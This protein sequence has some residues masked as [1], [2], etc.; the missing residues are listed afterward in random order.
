MNSLAH[1]KK[2]AR[3]IIE[4]V[5]TYQNLSRDSRQ[6]LL[7][8]IEKLNDHLLLENYSKL[9]CKLWWYRKNEIT[10]CVEKLIEYRDEI[11]KRKLVDQSNPIPTREFGSI[12]GP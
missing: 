8:D 5:D 4:T 6:T 10:Q 11:H 1:I 2:K 12:G 7:K 9:Y 3:E